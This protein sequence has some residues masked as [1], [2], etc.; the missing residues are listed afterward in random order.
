[1]TIAAAAEGG[2]ARGGASRAKVLSDPRSGA[3]PLGGSPGAGPGGSGAS[4]DPGPSRRRVGTGAGDRFRYER[5]DTAAPK[6]TPA[7]ATSSTRPSS[8]AAGPRTPEGRRRYAERRQRELGHEPRREA[9]TSKT[10]QRGGDW[11]KLS[12]GGSS[13]APYHNYQAIILAEFVGAELLVAASPM[14]TR[15]RG[16][17]LSPYVPKDL[18]QLVAIGVVYLVLELIASAGN[19]AGRFCAWL[20]GLILLTVGLSEAANIAQIFAFIT[21]GSGK[22]SSTI[23]LTA[24]G[25]PTSLQQYMQAAPTLTTNETLA[26][27]GTTPGTPPSGPGGS[28]PKSGSAFVS[29]VA[30]FIGTPY[31]WGGDSPGGFDCS[32]LVYYALRQLGV[33]NVPRTSEQQWG[34]VQRISESQLAP[35][36]LIFEQWPGEASPGHVAIYSGPG[37]IIQAPAPGEDVQRV[38]W[39]P[40]IVHGEGGQIVGYGRVPGLSY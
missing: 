18:V 2:A 37:Q 3:R 26:A 30:K 21:G 38:P 35:G 40:S 8:A 16:A 17:G 24:A 27:T 1:M 15:N 34:W 11:L 33:G 28:G 7:G 5:R 32:G 12:R 22:P 25:P 20:G 4:S 36:D 9:S 23:S 29:E 10:K 31:Q 19:T 39:S 13:P 6:R 14:A